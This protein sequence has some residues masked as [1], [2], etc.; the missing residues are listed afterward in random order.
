ML[1]VGVGWGS[2]YRRARTRTPLERQWLSTTERGHHSSFFHSALRPQKPYG[3]IGTG[4]EWHGMRAQ[5]HLPVHTAPEL[6]NSDHMDGRLLYM[7]CYAHVP[8]FLRSQFLSRLYKSPS[9]ETMNRIPPVCI[10]MQNDHNTHVKD[11]LYSI[12][13]FGGL[14]ISNS[15]CTKNVSLWTVEAGNYRRRRRSPLNPPCLLILG[16][17]EVNRST[18]MQIGRTSDPAGRHSGQAFDCQ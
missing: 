5:T 1:S 18:W 4:E 17:L 8:R 12:S 3:L 16:L 9:D 2:Q 14:W 7:L 6:C 15:E 10:W 11:P 13:E